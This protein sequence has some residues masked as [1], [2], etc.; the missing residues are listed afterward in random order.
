M[1]VFGL[2][3]K[4]DFILKTKILAIVGSNNKNSSTNLVVSQLLSNIK[5]QNNSYDYEIICLSDYA[6]KYCEGCETCFKQGFCPVD[7]KDDFEIIRHRLIEA[8]I[9]FLVSPVYVHNVPGIMKTFFDRMA[10]SCHLLDLAGKLGFTLTT[11]YSNGEEKVKAYL[12][13]LQRSMGIKNLNNYIYVRAMDLIN[14]FIEMSTM[15][16]LKNIE[17]NF[18]YSDRYL[19]ENFNKYKNMY[20]NID[21]QAIDIKEINT[22]EWEYWNKQWVKECKSFQEFA[23][24][25]RRLGARKAELSKGENR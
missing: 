1:F 3:Q 20:G 21:E 8:D 9:V 18:G 13:D 5:F 12:S 11:T 2:I 10:V 7:K 14:E 6:I 22:Y 24:K 16:F 23:V 4:G 19:E 17:L 15:S 25:T